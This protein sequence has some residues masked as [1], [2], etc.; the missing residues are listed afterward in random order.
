[1]FCILLSAFFAIS[2]HKAKIE[3]NNLQENGRIENP[4][5]TTTR[6]YQNLMT[7]RER[8]REIGKQVRCT[9]RYCINYVTE[10]IKFVYLYCNVHS[11]W[12]IACLAVMLQMTLKITIPCI[13][14]ERMQDISFVNRVSATFFSIIWIFFIL[15]LA[16]DI[17]FHTVRISKCTSRVWFQLK[18]MKD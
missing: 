12:D 17:D 18:W 9:V 10:M 14:A 13:Q 11:I 4:F 5:A 7:E 3:R 1:M 16:N 6:M 15:S 2:L 8:K